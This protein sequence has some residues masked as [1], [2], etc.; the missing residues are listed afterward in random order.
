V[1]WWIRIR[2]DDSQRLEVGTLVVD[3]FDAA[4]KEAL[5]WGTSTK[6]LSGNPDRNAENLNKAI[7]KMIREYPP[8]TRSGE[9]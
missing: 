3:L 9:N 5:S 7:A 1:G 8:S 6:T 4:T 2:D